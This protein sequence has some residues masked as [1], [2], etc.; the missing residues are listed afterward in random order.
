MRKHCERLRGDPGAILAAAAFVAET[1]ALHPSDR[2]RLAQGHVPARS[3]VAE[4]FAAMGAD[5]A[6]VAAATAAAGAGAP[7]I[8]AP[9][10]VGLC[11]LNQVDL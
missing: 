7:G 10:A 1:Q 9:T 8:T 3:P 11:R 4:T 5:G 2:N 6:L